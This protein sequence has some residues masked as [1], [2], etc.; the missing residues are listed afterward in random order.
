MAAA[1]AGYEAFQSFRRKAVTLVCFLLAASMAIGITVYVDSYSV[2]EWNRNVDVGDVA[3][4]VEGY[5]IESYVDDIRDI[6]SVTKAAALRNGY[7]D[8]LIQDN[9]TIELD[10]WGRIL[11]PDEDFFNA[12]PNYIQLQ[13]GRFPIDTDEIAAINSLHI[14]NGIEINDTLTLQQADDI[15]NVTVVGFYSYSDEADSPYFWSSDSIAITV[16]GVVSSYDD[17]TQVLV[18]IRRGPLSPFN[19]VA[20][21]QYLNGIDEAIRRVD[22]NYQPGITWPDFYVQNRLSSGIYNYISWVQM[23]RISQMLRASSVIFLLILVTFLAIRHNVNDRRYEENMLMSRGAAKGEL[24]KVTTREV[25]TL[26]ILSCLVGIPLG[27]L[28]SRIAISATGFFTFDLSLVFTE[29]MLISIDSLIISAVVTIALPLLTLG[30]YR[31]IYSTKKNVD[32]NVGKLAKL[33]RGLGIIRWDALI[34]ALSGLFLLAMVTGGSAATNNPILALILPILPIPLFLG[35]SSLSIKALR[36]G[37]NGLSRVMKRVVGDVSASIGV[38]RLGKASSSAGAASMILVLAICLSWNSAIID[39]SFPVTAQ[40]QSRLDIGADLTFALSQYENDSWDA[41]RA[42]VT[43]HELVTSGTTTSEAI[44]YLS[45]DYGGATSFLAVNPN[46]YINIGYDY[47][48]NQLNESDLAPMMESLESTIDGAIITSDIAEVYQ[49]EIGD[50]IRA[51]TL[52][53]E[54]STI[55]FRVIGI[56][57]A[58]PEMPVVDNYYPPYY[59]DDI[60]PPTIPYY[61]YY[62]REVGKSKILVNRDYLGTQITLQNMTNNYY[63]VKTVDNANAT[64]IVED[65]FAVGGAIALYQGMWEAVSKNVHDYLTNTEYIMDRALD[66]MLTVLTVGTIVGGFVIYAVEGVRARRREIALLRSVG[67]TRRTIVSA[68]GTEMLVLMLFSMILLLI[69]APLFLSITVNIAGGSTTGPS[70]IYPIPIFPVIPWFTI[71]EVL[72]FFVITVTVFIAIIAVY[73]TRI[74]LASTL[75]AAWAEAGPHGGDI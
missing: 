30:G 64:K 48:G 38:R 72:G 17:Q 25:L 70:D 1:P 61:Y 55:S 35:I 59:Y 67:A 18:D 45:A 63:C 23:L 16:E 52:Q 4:I 39:A 33:S 43:N 46:E 29:P 28:L 7:G 58:L 57:D 73:S 60:Y 36:F 32:A 5:N 54:A 27:L 62:Y 41:F 26:S 9:E 8:L 10:V 13:S 56:A 49:F 34:V 31:V 11:T 3:I 42:N 68:I 24:E 66:T 53:D 2:H 65:V 14:Y 44:L 15:R 71:F 47:R 37:A 74:N 50:I 20:S 40:N 21:L 75:N 69:Y 6:R 51:T 12:F 22:P 19:P